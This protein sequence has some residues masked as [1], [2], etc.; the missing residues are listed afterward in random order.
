MK[1]LKFYLAA[2]AALAVLSCTKDNIQEEIKNEDGGEILQKELV[3]LTFT[4]VGEIPMPESKTVI[5]SSTGEDGKLRGKINWENTDKIAVYA[6]GS[7]TAHP[8]DVTPDSGNPT[9]ATF[10]GEGFEADGYY[11]VYP[12]SAA[13]GLDGDVLTVT[14]P[15]VQ[16]VS[17]DRNVA[18]DALAGVAVAK[19]G[20]F[21]FKNI[22]GLLAVE[23]TMEGIV[24]I[25]VSGTGIS[26]KAKFKA[27]DGT[28]VKDASGEVLS[29]EVVLK[30]EDGSS[31]EA[32]LYFVTVLP[33]T[34]N[35]TVSMVR[36]KTEY[37]YPFKFAAD[38]TSK[39]E[40]VIN[41][42]GGLNFGQMDDRMTWYREIYTAEDLVAWN[43]SE[44]M[45]SAD[46]K[47]RL[48]A[49][50]DM[51]DKSWTPN[52]FAGVFD[53]KDHRIYNFT[54]T[55]ENS[56]VGFIN[57]LSGTLQNLVLGTSDGE[58]Y[59]EK[60]HIS[61]TSTNTTW[62][63]V[64]LVAK[65]TGSGTLTNVRNFAKIEILEGSTGQARAAGICASW[66]ATTGKISKCVNY[67]EVV[68]SS[69]EALAENSSVS[70]IISYNDNA[71]T[72]EDCENRGYIHSASPYVNYVAGILGAA[73][74]KETHI[75]RCHNYAKV[76]SY[77]S[78]EGS[79]GANSAINVAGI[80]GSISG[81][82]S[83][84]EDCEN[85]AGAEV[86]N[87][88]SVKSANTLNISGIVS[89]T[90][91]LTISGC[92]NYGTVSLQGTASRGS[93]VNAGGV[94]GYTN[95]NSPLIENCENHGTIRHSNATS[96]FC[97]LGGICGQANGKPS[98]K[99]C[100]NYG[101]VL[102]TGTSSHNPTAANTG[103]MLLGGVVGHINN[104]AT[105]T[106]CVNSET[107]V[108]EDKSASKYVICGGI[109]GKATAAGKI[110]NNC[111]NEG[112]IL[113]ST[114]SGATNVYM[115]GIVGHNITT[116][117]EKI[118]NCHNKGEVTNS[119]AVVTCV[120]LAG[121]IGYSQVAC[122]V[123]SCTNTALIS[124][125]GASKY[126][127]FGG[128]AGR[129]DAAGTISGCE[130]YGKV[131]NLATNATAGGVR[132]GGILGATASSP[133]VSGCTNKGDVANSAAVTVTHGVGGIIGY[134]TQTGSVTENCFVNC[135][136]SSTDITNGKVAAIIGYTTKTVTAKNNGVT[137]TVRGQ[138]LTATNYTGYLYIPST[139]ITVPEDAP[140]YFWTVPSTSSMLINPY[141]RTS[142]GTA[143]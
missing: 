93:Q 116:A 63:Y 132:I 27:A 121:I 50:I 5:E 55:G 86:I 103:G 138:K 101:T 112:K 32:G 91:D 75:R 104:A 15:E 62:N 34:R 47:V 92:K 143:W 10:T 140:N 14:I 80:C 9:S 8:F 129:Y 72:M 88:I 3:P 12:Y 28:R 20:K 73:S 97:R 96:T 84:V 36:E 95:T 26:G 19:D 109:V 68:H 44:I 25:R 78:P 43:K 141:T 76:V 82:S 66:Q 87:E 30:S 70:G 99:N 137:G 1:T 61:L 60:S 79:T 41:R 4:G 119:A 31:L 100:T 113:H 114:T 89:Y 57:Q 56:Y 107:G 136:L 18:E 130:N 90:T 120:H 106:G 48:A 117:L 71:L 64:G 40:A 52:N 16:K 131:D 22:F 139:S 13:G 17:S 94:V 51:T 118:E 122:P 54:C 21:S 65:A 37:E 124:S 105:L 85:K 2:I 39:G 38:A 42:N 127:Y 67:G 58:T 45:G 110:Y 46:E 24:Q 69:S 134:I 81:E 35:L 6:A 111:I 123:T 11:A 7:G 29:D 133:T 126:T 49:N 115:G 33:G 128:I 108:V 23:V 53:G 125:S 59:D 83:T 102:N 142:D 77:A 98:F 74:T 135:V